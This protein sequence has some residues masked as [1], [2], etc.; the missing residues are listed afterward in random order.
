VKLTEEFVRDR[1]NT[2]GVG[3]RCKSCTAKRSRGYRHTR[4]Y[5]LHKTA[6]G[7]YY[8]R[9]CSDPCYVCEKRW[10]KNLIHAH[11]RQPNEKKYNLNKL[12]CKSEVFLPL[13]EV[14]LS[15]CAPLCGNCHGLVHVEMQNGGKHLTF[16]ELVALVRRKYYPETI[17]AL[18]A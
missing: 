18:T 11:H 16:D 5:G 4:K 10:H 13:I 2:N 6:C 3:C 17:P 12:T 7:D 14:E 8:D 15:K 1:R 9:W